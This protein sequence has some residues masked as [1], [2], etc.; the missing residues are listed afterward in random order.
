MLWRKNS[1]KRNGAFFICW[2]VGTVGTTNG[3]GFCK[4]KSSL[5]ELAPV[6]QVLCGRTKWE[7]KMV[8]QFHQVP[9]TRHYLLTHV[10]DERQQL[11][12]TT[13]ALRHLHLW[14]VHCFAPARHAHCRLPCPPNMNC[15]RNASLRPNVRFA[16]ATHAHALHTHNKPWLLWK[17]RKGQRAR[18]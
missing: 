4:K 12:H 10:I 3:T 8:Q 11:V 2:Q 17:T 13:P 18:T 6:V 7:C 5:T 14:V 16:S 9:T 1:R 15:S